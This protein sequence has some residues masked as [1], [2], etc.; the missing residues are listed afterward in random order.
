M[1]KLSFQAFA[2]T[3]REVKLEILS[4]EGTVFTSQNLQLRK[5]L[6]GYEIGI[7]VD[8][9]SEAAFIKAMEKSDWVKN[10]GPMTKADDG[11]YYLIPGKYDIRLSQVKLISKAEFT[12]K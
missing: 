10:K 2:D 1:P 7:R 6:S 11:F 12:I 9:S 4:T 3:D 5:G 8:K